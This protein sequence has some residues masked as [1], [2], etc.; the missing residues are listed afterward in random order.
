MREAIGQLITCFNFIKDNNSSGSTILHRKSRRISE[1][2]SG[3]TQ[4]Q[5]LEI[6]FALI[7]ENG[8]VVFIS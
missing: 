6:E 3:V 7:H 2:W 8:D 5:C 1:R 4:I